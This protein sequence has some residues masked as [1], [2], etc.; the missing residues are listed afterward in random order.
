MERMVHHKN[1]S[2][3]ISSDQP[4]LYQYSHGEIASIQL[5]INKDS[6]E[7]TIVVKY[8]SGETYTWNSKHFHGYINQ[9][10]IAVSLD[11]TKVF[12]QTWENGL[13]C[14][15]AMTGERIWR[16][17]SRRGITNIFVNDDTVT[18]QLH[19]FAMQ[20]LDMNTGEV[21]QEKRPCTAWGFTALGNRYIICQTT[22]RKWELIEPYT[23]SVKETFNHKEFTGN[24]TNFAIRH[25]T[26]GENGTICVEGFRNAWDTTTVPPTMLPNIEF[27]YLLK[28]KVLS[29]EMV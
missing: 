25:I 2:I 26:L 7:N 23:L 5:R 24:H 8:R 11:G 4:W 20:L 29:G 6:A 28:S 21:I 22:A 15:N 13:F 27:E 3:Y 9:F 10:G 14:F 17:K 19:D 16:T 18:V 1:Y 12:A